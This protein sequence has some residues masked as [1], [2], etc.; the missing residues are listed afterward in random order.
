MAGGTDMQLLSAA[1]LEAWVERAE[2]GAEQIYAAGVET[3]RGSEVGLAALRLIAEGLIVTFQTG[4]PGARNYI[5]R[6]TAQAGRTIVQR[7]AAA[8][9]RSDMRA[10]LELLREAARRG[11]P[12]PTNKRIAELC[13]L[14]TAL[15]AS[16]RLRCLREQGLI[17]IELVGDSPGRIITIRSSGQRTAILPAYAERKA[18]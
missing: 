15:A 14:P 7:P 10:V 12:C 16:Y 1:A 17:D 2:A 13:G 4:V 11:R 6:R 18:G 8:Q 5:A 9:A 3:V